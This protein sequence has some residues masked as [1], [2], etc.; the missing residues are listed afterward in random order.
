MV[1][2]CFRNFFWFACL[3]VPFFGDVGFSA[4]S[5]EVDNFIFNRPD[6]CLC[7]F[8]WFCFALFLYC[9]V[10]AICEDPRGLAMRG[11]E[12]RIMSRCIHGVTP[13]LVYR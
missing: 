7:D 3:F 1:C 10:S 6:F 2:C 8:A 13:E 12:H 11:K 4:Q 9:S 5:R